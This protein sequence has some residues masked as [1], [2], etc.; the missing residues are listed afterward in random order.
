MIYWSHQ[1]NVCQSIH[2]HRDDGD[3]V[4]TVIYEGCT[5]TIENTGCGFEPIP[6]GPVIVWLEREEP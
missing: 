5:H 1:C 4:D 2:I 6:K 3:F